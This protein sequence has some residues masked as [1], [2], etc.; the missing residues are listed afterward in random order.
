MDSD[1]QSFAPAC[2]LG[3]SSEQVAGLFGPSRLDDF[4]AFM[5]MKARARYDEDR[6][7]VQAHDHV[8]YPVDVPRFIEERAQ[9]SPTP[10][11]LPQVAAIHDA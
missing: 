11:D 10:P 8:F 2:T 7:S 5:M 4:Q 9:P 6:A 3:Y 1:R